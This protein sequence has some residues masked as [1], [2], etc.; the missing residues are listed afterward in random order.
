MFPDYHTARITSLVGCRGPS[1]M[2]LALGM[3]AGAALWCVILLVATGWS[4]FAWLAGGFTLVAIAALFVNR[5]RPRDAAPGGCE[6]GRSRTTAPDPCGPA[7]L[8]L[9][10]ID[11]RSRGVDDR[12]PA[13]GEARRAAISGTHRWL[14]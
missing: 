1:G 2:G 6:R 14:H 3:V 10:G 13:P 5:P 4:G 12:A 7:E 9:H 8:E 11:A